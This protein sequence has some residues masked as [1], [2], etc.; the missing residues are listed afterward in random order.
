M[1]SPLRQ[2][3]EARSVT[4]LSALTAAP[5]WVLF[6]VVLAVVTGGLLLTGTPALLLLLALAA[7][8]GW[9]AYLAWPALAPGQ[10]LLRLLTVLLVAGAAYARFSA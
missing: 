8:L 3:V 10:R 1:T 9:L 5:K 7:F 2:A 6:L 4:A